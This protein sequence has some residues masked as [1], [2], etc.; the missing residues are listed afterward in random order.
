[1]HLARISLIFIKLISACI[2]ARY[3]ELN[4]GCQT[5]LKTITLPEYREDEESPVVSRRESNAIAYPSCVR[6]PRCSGCCG[7]S[8]A[9]NLMLSCVPTNKTYER[10][11]QHV[12]TMRTS[13]NL[14]WPS[15][16]TMMGGSSLV[17]IKRYVNVEVHLACACLCPNNPAGKCA[18]HKH[19]FNVETCN[20][21]CY[22]EEQRPACALRV[23]NKVQAMFW[24]ANRCRCRCPQY[25]RQ[26]IG[27]AI[28]PD[29]VCSEGYSFDDDICR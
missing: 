25:Y 7:E 3:V 26:Y 23:V 27:S 11:L 19:R 6:V 9:D 2:A 20:C 10:V 4:P 5:E 13:N 22:N 1:M 16:M 18:S 24:D 12:Q 14:L 21:E 15:W 8:S 28:F 17:M 29:I